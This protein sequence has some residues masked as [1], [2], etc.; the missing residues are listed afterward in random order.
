MVSATP[1]I[2]HDQISTAR[3]QLKKWEPDPWMFG[4]HTTERKPT[5]P[6]EWFSK[7]FPVQAHI[8]GC[9]FIELAEDRSDGLKKI[10]PLSAN[11]DF[12]AA[13]LG[14]DEKMGHKIIYLE[15]E[16]Q[17][18]Y[19]DQPSNI[20]KPTADEKLA[21]LLRA[22]LIRC[23]EELPDNVHKL[24]LF[25]EFR[26]DK[27]IRAV[28]HRAKSILAADHTFFCTDSKNARQKGL[29]VHERLAKVF[30]E[31]ILERQP[32]EVLTLTNAYLVFIE[33]LKQKSMVP[34]KRSIFKGMFTP[35]IR[36]AFN[37]GLRNDVIDQATNHQTA[38]WKGLRALE[39]QEMAEKGSNS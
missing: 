3:L 15:G 18:Y 11:L 30:V 20:F 7:M 12:L 10:N 6:S 36:D 21:N 23:A 38:G 19:L 37:L 14:G 27:T 26:S 2:I 4:D 39:V 8:H 34:V 35:L 5:T 1:E 33:F 17:W 29:E 28:V 32:G 13:I 9:P 31:Q 16:M 22:L 24:N 25:L